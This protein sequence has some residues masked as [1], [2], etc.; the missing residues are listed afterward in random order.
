[1]AAAE[2]S[3]IAAL[4]LGARPSL[5]R[6]TVVHAIESTARPLAGVRYGMVDALAAVRAAVPARASRAGAETASQESAATT[7]V[8]TTA[9][10]HHRIG[11]AA[12]LAV[13][14]MAAAGAAA[15]RAA[16]HRE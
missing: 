1:M 10:P 12:L 13:G 14:A 15:G 5:R 8:A 4:V 11:G 7:P 3:G 6:A 16:R 2:V 9:T